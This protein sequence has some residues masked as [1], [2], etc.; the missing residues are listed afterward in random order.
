MSRSY[1]PFTVLML[2]SSGLVHW[3]LWRWLGHVWPR[4]VSRWRRPILA[5]L[6][7]SYALPPLYRLVIARLPGPGTGALFALAMIWQVTLWISM[8]AIGSGKAV[9]YLF[10]TWRGRRGTEAEP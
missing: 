6:L 3:L 10:T 1:L 4:G 2:V 7:I 8:A 5:M 9:E